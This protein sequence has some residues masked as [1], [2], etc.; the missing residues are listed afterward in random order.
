MV[1]AG[2]VGV[3]TM[4]PGLASV[5][6]AKLENGGEVSRLVCAGECMFA[7]KVFFFCGGI[8]PQAC[9][10]GLTALG[11]GSDGTTTIALSWCIHRRTK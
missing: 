8:L 9:G 10:G 7:S 3:R 1:L 5:S 11:S 6:W 2:L 4:F